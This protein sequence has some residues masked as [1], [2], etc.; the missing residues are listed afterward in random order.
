MFYALGSTTALVCGERTRETAMNV[1]RLDGRLLNYWVAKSA[2][3]TLNEGDSLPGRRH[4]P[5]SGF[6]HPHS[7]NPANDWSHAGP[8]ISE[9]WFAIEDMLIEWFGVQW[10]HIPAVSDHP[11]TWFLRAYVATQYGDEV[12]DVDTAVSQPAIEHNYDEDITRAPT[13]DKRP[14]SWLQALFRQFSW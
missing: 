8:I 2:G 12:E 3:L 13:T 7:Y 6:W 4:D 14:K 9:E 5:D 11:L 1:K 10:S